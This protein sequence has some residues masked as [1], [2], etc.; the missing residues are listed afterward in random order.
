MQTVLTLWTI[1][2]AI[3]LLVIVPLVIY[4]LHRTWRAARGI[5]RYF[6]EMATAGVGIAGNTEHIKALESTIS[7]A[8]GILATAGGINTKA[9]IIKKTLLARAGA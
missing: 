6:A 5:E 2:L 4:L 8:G 1:L 7:V 3:T 9:E